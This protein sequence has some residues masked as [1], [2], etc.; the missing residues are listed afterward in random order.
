MAIQN[1]A[2]EIVK[3]LKSKISEEGGH[4]DEER[5]NLMIAIK[6]SND[7][8]ARK[9]GRQFHHSELLKKDKEDNNLLHFACAA[10]C[11]GKMVNCVFG[12]L[13]GKDTE[14]QLQLKGMLQEKNKN[15]EIPLH[16]LASNKNINLKY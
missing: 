14:G 10:E 4:D 11:P 5:T 6:S 7:E 9:L 13:K 1:N 8:M 2:K 15:K 16:I 3:I 12:L